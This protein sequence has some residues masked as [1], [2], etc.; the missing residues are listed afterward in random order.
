M[1]FFSSLF[2]SKTNENVEVLTPQ[3]YK[4][5]ISKKVQLIDVRTPREYASGHIKGAKNIDFFSPKFKEACESLNKEQP[6][7]IYCQSGNRSRSASGR[8]A[9]M[10]FIEIYDLQGGYSNWR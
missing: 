4:D 5:R 7:Y 8:L 2:K 1:S 9:S 3:D 10:G 6:I